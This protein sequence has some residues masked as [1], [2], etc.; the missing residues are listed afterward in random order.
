MKLYNYRV[1]LKDGS[2]LTI[3]AIGPDDARILAK[4]MF[5]ANV[6]SV[7]RILDSGRVGSESRE[8]P[9]VTAAAD[10][11]LE[12]KR[13][14]AVSVVV[15]MAK[16]RARLD[17]FTGNVFDSGLSAAENEDLTEIF[18]IIPYD[19]VEEQ[20]LQMIYAG[21]YTREIG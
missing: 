15:A 1:T 10:A 5:G 4:K 3:Q 9:P 19:R 13:A 16:A 14:E 2:L 12:L 8:V 17:L 21:A 18:C 7:R 20:G 6:V 11:N